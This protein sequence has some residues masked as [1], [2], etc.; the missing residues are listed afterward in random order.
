M[1]YCRTRKCSPS[2]QPTPIRKA[3]VPAPPASPVVSVSRNTARRRSND[4]SSGSAVSTP[5]VPGSIAWK[6][7]SGTSPC[8]ISRWTELS[9]RKNSPRTFSIRIPSTSSS[10]GT[11]AGPR[12]RSRSVAAATSRSSRALSG[13]YSSGTAATAGPSSSRS[14]TSSPTLEPPRP[15]AGLSRW[16]RSWRDIPSRGVSSRRHDEGYFVCPWIRFRPLNSS[17]DELSVRCSSAEHRVQDRQRHFLAAAADLARRPHARRAPVRTRAGGNQRPA[18]RQQPV[19]QPIERLGQPDPA[20]IGVVDEHVRLVVLAWRRLV[21]PAPHAGPEPQQPALDPRLSLPVVPD[22]DPEVVPVAHQEERCE[23]AERV[24]QGD[25][26]VA[27]LLKGIRQRSHHRAR[28]REPVRGGVHL[29]LGHRQLARADVLVGVE[30][31]LLEAHDLRG[32]V[33]LAVVAQPQAAPL[34]REAL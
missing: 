28:H 27:P 16:S 18:L 13:R 8:R 6:R 4:S 19:V 1:K 34:L 15:T 32:D 21:P 33:H 5:I 9:T 23:L 12:R 3:A 25:D 30:L 29:V 20:R 2:T 10:S 7:D 14:S 17:R 26:A 11:G 31:D 24:R 22:R